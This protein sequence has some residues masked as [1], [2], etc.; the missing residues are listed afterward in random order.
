MT[1]ESHVGIEQISSNLMLNTRIKFVIFHRHITSIE[2]ER[3]RRISTNGKRNFVQVLK[4]RS[5]DDSV[6]NDLFEDRPYHRCIRFISMRT[7]DAYVIILRS[8]SILREDVKE[9]NYLKFFFRSDVLEFLPVFWSSYSLL[10]LI[11]ISIL[12]SKERKKFDHRH[13]QIVHHFTMMWN[14]KER[15]FLFSLDF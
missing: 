2:I 1:I 13:C 6:E 11:R 4:V 9:P 3:S 8:I 14:E 5:I 10:F 7:I 12:Q 15:N